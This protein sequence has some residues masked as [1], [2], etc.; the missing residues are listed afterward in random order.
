M[1][2]RRGPVATPP[3]RCPGKQRSTSPLGVGAGLLSR[4]TAPLLVL[5]ARDA[6]PWTGRLLGGWEASSGRRGL[7]APPP[8][9]RLDEERPTRQ[10]GV[11]WPLGGRRASS[12]RRRP[13]VAPPRRCLDKERPARQ[14]RVDAAPS[15]VMGRLPARPA[16]SVRG[17]VNG[18]AS[19][20]ERCDVGA[21]RRLDEE[22]PTQKLRV[23]DA[24]LM[25]PS[26]S[27]FLARRGTI[28]TPLCRRLDKERPAQQL[29]VNNALLLRSSASTLVVWAR[30]A[31][32]SMGQRL[33]GRGAMLAHHGPIATP[34][35]CCSDGERSARQLRVD[36]ALLLRP[37]PTSAASSTG[38]TLD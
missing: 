13:V 35:H 33:W 20:G 26:A 23:N 19:L 22:R 28:A 16:G 2:G 4:P 32:L 3:Y 36:T 7:V 21:R 25:R 6:A 30:D 10:L 11:D 8:R 15:D 14:L 9:R 5:R 29:R 38:G 27:T 18:L 12:G 24:L 37:A 31:A 17:A 1:S 34:P